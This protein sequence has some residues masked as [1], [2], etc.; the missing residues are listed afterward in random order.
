MPPLK[1]PSTLPAKHRRTVS[2]NIGA[3]LRSALDLMVFG[4]TE[5]DKA[6]NA[7]DFS[8]AARAVGFNVRA[9]RKA[10]ERPHVR[11]YLKAQKEVFRASASAQNISALVKLRDESGNGMVQLG[12]IKTLEQMTDDPAAQGTPQARPGLVIVVVNGANQPQAIEHSLNSSPRTIEM[13][14]NAQVGA[15]FGGGHSDDDE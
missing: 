6:G 11:A 15:P 12:A 2:N 14:A 5:G 13:P 10:L 8:D 9:M 4:L 7:L 3:K 1:L